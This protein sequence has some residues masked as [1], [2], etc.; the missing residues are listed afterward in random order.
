MDSL[1]Y[2][3]RYDYCRKGTDDSSLKIKKVTAGSKRVPRSRKKA[4][5]KNKKSEE[6]FQIIIEMDSGNREDSDE[7]SGKV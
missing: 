4:E 3:H 6:G 5:E 7:G 1:Q 2:G